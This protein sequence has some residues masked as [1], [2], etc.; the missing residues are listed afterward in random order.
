MALPEGFSTKNSPASSPFSTT[1]PAGTPGGSQHVAG[2]PGAIGPRR[3]HFVTGAPRAVLNPMVWSGLYCHS[4]WANQL[5]TELQR[6]HQKTK[7][8]SG[9]RWRVKSS[10]LSAD[11]C[12]EW[13]EPHTKLGMATQ[14]KSIFGY[15]LRNCRQEVGEP[16]FTLMPRP[17]STEFWAPCLY[18]TGRKYCSLWLWQPFYPWRATHRH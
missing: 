10:T 14:G 13:R 4:T 1:R 12:S 9:Q 8:W 17:V 2:V 3:N 11:M 16:A 18:L 5:E 7:T 6:S 15:R